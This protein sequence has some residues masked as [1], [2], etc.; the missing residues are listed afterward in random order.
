LYAAWLARVHPDAQVRANFRDGYTD[1]WGTHPGIVTAAADYYARLQYPDGSWRWQDD[2]NY[3]GNDTNDGLG[4]QPFMVGLLLHGMADVHRLIDGDATYAAQ[5]ATIKQSIMR[6]AEGVYATGYR[7]D[8][9]VADWST[10]DSS[11]ATPKWRGMWYS[12]YNTGCATG[13]GINAVQGDGNVLREV[14]Q[15][16]ATVV[17]AFGYAYKISGEERFRQWGD[18]VFDATYGKSDVSLGY[19]LPDYLEKQY[20]QAYRSGGRYLAWRGGGVSTAPTPAPT[21]TP[22]PTPTPSATPTPKPTPTPSATPTPTPTP[23]PRGN[24]SGSVGKAKKNAQT[25]SN[26]LSATTPTGVKAEGAGQETS[27]V[28]A[29]NYS[30]F[31]Q[32]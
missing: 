24:A 31:N 29:E 25:L 32:L 19:G 28:S 9:S 4:M 22:T 20:N 7:K 5:A 14:R 3:D 1:Q 13:C 30:Q 16:N 10:W 6:G 8:G 15:L 2:F 26:Q 18:E 21:P 17:H 12:V 23:T 11:G 27:M